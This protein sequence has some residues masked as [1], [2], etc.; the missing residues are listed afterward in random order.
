MSENESKVKGKKIH[1]ANYKIELMTSSGGSTGKNQNYNVRESV[2][3]VI[4]A[5]EQKHKGFI[6]LQYMDIAK[7]FL[8]CKEDYL[9]LTEDEYEKVYRA[10]DNFTGFSRF[11]GELLQRIQDAEEVELEEKKDGPQLIED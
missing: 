8:D 1:I 9:I 5:P 6:H 10:F 11:D 4:T 3:N 7:K 2:V